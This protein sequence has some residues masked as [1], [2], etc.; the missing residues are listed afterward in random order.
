M[1]WKVP[2]QTFPV[3]AGRERA[4]P[5]R[6]GEGVSPAGDAGSVGGAGSADVS[7]SED[8]P[9]RRLSASRCRRMPSTR[10]SISAAARRVNVSRRMRPGSVPSAILQATRWARVAVLP[11]PAP[12]TISSGSLPCRT[13][14]RCSSFSSARTVAIGVPEGASST[15]I[16]FLPSSLGGYESIQRRPDGTSPRRVAQSGGTTSRTSEGQTSSFC[17]VFLGAPPPR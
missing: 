2:P 15:V 7:G 17:W 12:A 5:W 16:R 4:G 3:A 9:A 11:V 8:A 13:A 6:A 14:E 1:A 10:R